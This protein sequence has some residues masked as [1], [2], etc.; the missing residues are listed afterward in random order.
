MFLHPIRILVIVATILLPAFLEAEERPNFIVIFCDDLGYADI[1]PFGS[2]LHRT[3][4]LD[5]MAEEG[6]KFTQFYST[7]GVCT[8]S[9]ASLLT[10]AYPRRIGMHENEAG[11]WVLFPGNS[12]GLHPDEITIADLLGREGYATACVG[13]WHLG[14]QPEFLP[15]RQGFDRYFGIPFSNDMGE[16]D[17]PEGMYPPLPLLRD[18]EVIET[19]PDQRF[20]TRRYTEEALRFLRENKDRPFFL[21]LPHTMPHW[22]QYSSPAFAGRSAN[23]AWGDTVEE[24]DWST[25]EILGELDTLGLREKTLVLFTSDNGGATRHGASNRPLSGAKGTTMEGGQ[26]IPMLVSWPGRIPE[27][28]LC[29]AV[30][31]TLDLLPTFAALAGTSSPGDRTLDGHDIRSLLLG[32]GEPNSP[33]ESFLYY[34]RGS[35]QAIRSGRWKLHFPRGNGKGALPLRL[36]DLEADVGETVNRAHG[37]PGV[38]ERLQKLADRAREDLGDDATGH[39]GTAL[40]KPGQ[41]ENAVPLT[42]SEE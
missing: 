25:G 29:E 15:T 36:F 27:G 6:R 16:V 30:T 17:R 12:R 11:R 13:K 7:C 3:P 40:R 26:R 20:I 32:E 4:N 14:D 22:P 2:T 37:E 8:P 1:G 39:P 9:R 42:S 31:S 21:Y 34:H 35:L 41:V 28:T 18:E 38:V 33:Y 10:G 5:R 23:G 24:I 19:E